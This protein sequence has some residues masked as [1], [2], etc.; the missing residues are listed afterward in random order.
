MDSNLSQS[1]SANSTTDTGTWQETVPSVPP[2]ILKR[3]LVPAPSQP[4]SSSSP[5]V[6]GYQQETTYVLRDLK[7]ALYSVPAPLSHCLQAVL[8]SQEPGGRL[9]R[10]QL[11]RSRNG[12]ILGSSPFSHGQGAV[13][14]T[15]EP[16]GETRS[17][18]V[19]EPG[20]M[21]SILAVEPETALGLNCS[22]FQP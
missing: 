12:P 1:Q 18:M 15:Q 10:P 20:L 6:P 19:P 16:G 5:E 17:S 22:A 21:T 7:R 8:P 14:P 9:S 2:E 11:R 3:P 4:Q 13:R